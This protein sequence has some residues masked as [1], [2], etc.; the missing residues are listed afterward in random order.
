MSTPI[1]KPRANQQENRFSKTQL[2]ICFKSKPLLTKYVSAPCA[3]KKK[4]DPTFSFRLQEI[5]NANTV[6]D[7][8]ERFKGASQDEENQQ[9][10]AGAHHSEGSQGQL[11]FSCDFQVPV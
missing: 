1:I 7:K 9:G 3:G 5:V 4:K 6:L 8:M 2:S 10:K 11:I